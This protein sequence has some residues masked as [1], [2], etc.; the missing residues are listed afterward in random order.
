MIDTIRIILFL[1]CNMRCSYCCNKQEQFNRQ[2]QKKK[3]KEI[4]FSKYKNVCITGGEPFLNKF[5]VLYP[6]LERIPSDKNLYIYTNGTKI[7]AFDIWS[8][9][10]IKNLK[11]INV[12]LHTPKQLGRIIHIEHEL[13]VRFM[14]PIGMKQKILTIYKDRLMT[15]NIKIFNLNDCD[16]HNEDWVL[17]EEDL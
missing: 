11:C 13:P 5:R 7:T 12:G 9:K 4:D 6:I 15:H 17:L 10:Q 1:D 8:L 14:I 3:F 2:F 16:M